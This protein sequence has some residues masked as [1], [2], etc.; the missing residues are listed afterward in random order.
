MPIGTVRPKDSFTAKQISRVF[1][2]TLYFKY[3]L[4]VGVK[5]WCSVHSD[6]IIIPHTIELVHRGH[7]G[8]QTGF[9]F[10]AKNI[11]KGATFLVVLKYCF[12]LEMQL[13]AVTTLGH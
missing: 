10:G 8:Y 12:I 6:C 4:R 11:L 3:D 1:W 2:N 5:K 7:Q 9:D 13:P